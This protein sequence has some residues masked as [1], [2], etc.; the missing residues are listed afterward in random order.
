MNLEILSA[1]SHELKDKGTLNLVPE[2]M[3]DFSIAGTSKC[4]S[5]ISI[6][7]L[8]LIKTRYEGMENRVSITGVIS[9]I[10]TRTGIKGFYRGV[11]STL[12]RDIPFSG[13]QFLIYKSFLNLEHKFFNGSLNLLTFISNRFK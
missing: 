1:L 12:I 5:A 4:L 11:I 10:Y 9:D 13:I 8:S 2:R 7:P 3:I 6:T